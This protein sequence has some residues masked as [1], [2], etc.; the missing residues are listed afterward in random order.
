MT[1]LRVGDDIRASSRN[2]LKR[3]EDAPLGDVMNDVHLNAPY[4]QGAVTQEGAAKVLPTISES[5]AFSRSTYRRKE[6]C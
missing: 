4:V 1:S 2:S 6:V 5:K 3:K